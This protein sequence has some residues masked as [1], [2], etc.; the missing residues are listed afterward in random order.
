MSSDLKFYR[1]ELLTHPNIPK[2]LHGLAPRVVNGRKWWDKV[3]QE[4]YATNN[5]RCWACGVP[6]TEALYRNWLEA[7]ESYDIDYATGRV[8]LK[9][10][11][12]LCYACHNF[13]HSGRLYSLCM[14]QEYGWRR[15]CEILNRGIEFLDRYGLKPYFQARFAQLVLCQSKSPDDATK[16]VMIEGLL[17]EHDKVA[18][19]QDWHLIIDGKRHGTKFKD[20]HDWAKEYETELDERTSKIA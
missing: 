4:A 6:K 2:P 8:E 5:Y 11:V 9:E 20:I 17:P 1:P 7:H 13:I 15:A 14:K 16:L 18:K 3:R 10:I 19:W 12:A